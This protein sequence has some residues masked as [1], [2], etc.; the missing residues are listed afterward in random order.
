MNCKN[1]NTKLWRL[2]AEQSQ[3]KC[4][5][6][7]L[8]KGSLSVVPSNMCR[9]PGKP[10]MSWVTPTAQVFHCKADMHLPCC[11]FWYL[12]TPWEPPACPPGSATPSGSAA[13]WEPFKGHS[14]QHRRW[15][16][17]LY[18]TA[19]PPHTPSWS[20]EILTA[21]SASPASPNSLLGRLWVVVELLG[22][23]TPQTA[24]N[25]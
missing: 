10:Y 3:R 17:F 12:S 9:G 22:S 16:Y 6:C 2:P 5:W 1:N 25:I 23:S 19:Q 18:V 15:Q 7:L 20:F 24:A 8:A 11:R 4:A 13:E 14:W 21:V